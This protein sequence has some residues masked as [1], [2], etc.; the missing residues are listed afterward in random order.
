MFPLEI[1]PWP[2]KGGSKDYWY[3]EL[4]HQNQCTCWSV[5][6]LFE[7]KESKVFKCIW[8]LSNEKRK[9]GYSPD[10]EIDNY[11]DWKIDDCDAFDVLTTQVCSTCNIKT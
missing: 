1:L 2:G 9:I 4:W 7:V 11:S 3:F 5:L 8:R 10:E 6:L